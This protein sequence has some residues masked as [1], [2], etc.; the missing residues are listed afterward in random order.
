MEGGREKNGGIC[1]SKPEDGDGDG[2]LFCCEDEEGGRVPE[3]EAPETP[4][5][6]AAAGVERRRAETKGGFDA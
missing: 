5:A 3:N 1:R 2:L 4:A 6:D